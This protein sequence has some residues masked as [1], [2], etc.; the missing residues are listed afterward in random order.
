MKL[1]DGKAVKIHAERLNIK[2]RE[3][4]REKSKRRKET[5][6]LDHGIVR[7][8]KNKTRYETDNIHM[9]CTHKYI[10]LRKLRKEHKK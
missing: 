1:S 9:L 7:E 5:K 8:P 4:E 3:R 10:L 6:I 2:K